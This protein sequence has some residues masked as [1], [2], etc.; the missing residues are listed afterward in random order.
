MNTTMKF[1]SAN[2]QQLAVDILPP[3]RQ[4]GG[5]SSKAVVFA[6]LDRE[7]AE[8]APNGALVAGGLNRLTL[9]EQVLEA[10]RTAITSGE[11]RPGSALGEVE[12]AARYGVSRGTVREALRFLQQSR[13]VSGDARGKLQVHRAT[14]QEI[15]EI[16]SVRGALEGLA[17]QT[18]VAM[19]D[20][21]SRVERLRKALPPE[22]LHGD[23][24]LHMNLD[25]AFHE[26]LA[27]LS[28]NATLLDNWRMLEDRMR[29]VFFSTDST[30]PVPI[31]A[32]SHHRP[33]VDAIEAG[34]A[35]Q[36]RR[37]V[38]LHMNEASRVW[39]PDI[40]VTPPA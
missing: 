39:A 37:T 7:E 22:D 2:C 28:G 19:P 24:T 29:I 32:R 14:P 10:L 1:V 6:L 4:S 33:I 17:V 20:R 30:R 5:S 15:A 16:F 9:R 8:M 18:I 27:E 40:E 36:A 21:R 12:I 31:M 11:L 25:L 35:H 3:V 26:C 23:F 34:D 38:H 13:L